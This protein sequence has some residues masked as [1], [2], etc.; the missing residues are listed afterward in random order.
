MKIKSSCELTIRKAEKKDSQQLI[1]Y[2]KIVRGESDNLLATPNDPLPTLDKEEKFIEYFNNA[3]SSVLLVG[4]IDNEV[5]GIG[6]VSENTKERILHQGSIA[7]S[8]L[9][10]YWG[11]GVGTAL[12]NALVDFARSA[13]TLEILHL[14]VK[15]D[16]LRGVNLYKKVG[17]EEIGR[18]PKFFKINGE[19]YDEI[20]MNLYL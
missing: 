11:V 3:K 20:L 16:N 12:M 4:F 2:L 19:Y 17:F 1:E 13:G 14:G 18:Y 8:V 15:A 9:K 10:K 6:S 7:M 5:V